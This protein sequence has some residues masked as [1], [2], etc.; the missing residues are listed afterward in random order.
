M[1]LPDPLHP[2]LVH[3]PLALAILLPAIVVVVWLG[4]AKGRWPASL[5]LLVVGLQLVLSLT[6]FVAVRTGSAEEELLEDRLPRA[7]LHEHEEAAE[8]FAW[9]TLVALAIGLLPMVVDRPA[10]RPWLTGLT[11]A[12]TLVVAGLAVKTGEAGG[13]LVWTH[14]APGLRLEARGLER[15]APVW[16]GST[17]QDADDDEEDAD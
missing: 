13:E 8:T 2:A 3:L 12:A 17:G 6:A 16:P 4:R 10:F 7:A 1:A 14:D 9:A 11:L 15:P 5:G